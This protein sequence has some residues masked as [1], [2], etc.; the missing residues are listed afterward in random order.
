MKAA[1][2]AGHEMTASAGARALQDGG[3]AVDAVVASG[4]MSWAA[5]PALTGPCGGGFVLVRPVRRHRAALLDAFTAIPGRD[6]PPDRRLAEVEEVLVPFDER[7]TQVF[8]VGSA[9]CAV[10]GVVAGLYEVHRRHGRLPWKQLLLPAAEAADRGVATNPGQQRV[11]DAIRVILTRT[12]EALEIFAPGGTFIT[13]GSVIRQPELARSIELLAER[14]PDELYR[15]ALGRAIVEHQHRHG[16]RL[17]LADLES[18]RPIWRRPLRACYRG[19]DLLTNPPPSSGGVLIAHMLGVLDGIPPQR[20]PGTA[21]ALRALAESMRSAARLRDRRF[22]TLL[23]RGGLTR[24]VL[25]DEAIAAG[26]EA[27]RRA[28]EG[29]SPEVSPAVRSDAGTTHISVVDG[30]GNAA[31]FTASNGSHSGVIV[32]GT[33]IHLN[34]MMG[35]EDLA[36]GRD[37]APGK[38]LTS[39]QAPTMMECDGS[40]RLVVGSS[41]SNR[42]RSAIMQVV[43]NVVDHGMAVQDAVSFPRIHVEGPRLDAEGGFDP[44][45]LDRLE[46]WGETVVRFDSLNLY[47]GGA[48]AV[49]VDGGMPSAAGDPRRDCAGIVLDV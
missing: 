38:R 6:L 19:H 31:A 22:A 18:Y 13:A 47:F 26:R 42:L 35:E 24:H 16:G 5:E 34:N 45:E 36:A 48:N 17:T 20:P 7:T 11:F 32:P 25:S 23:H 44:A 46:A 2:A 1:I 30:Q 27:V 37:L 8:H 33:G 43:V 12:P 15:G 14:G 41:G 49:L 21:P 9:T 4:A 39:M 3:N 29:A 40:I 10:P 28:L